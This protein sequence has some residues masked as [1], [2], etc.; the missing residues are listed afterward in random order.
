MGKGEKLIYPFRNL[1]PEAHPVL[2][3]YWREL[4]HTTN[5]SCKG[6]WVNTYHGFL[7]CIVEGNKEKGFWEA[8]SQCLPQ[9]E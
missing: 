5:R 2:S 9:T 7:A 4:G 3:A 8:E 6:V 1:L